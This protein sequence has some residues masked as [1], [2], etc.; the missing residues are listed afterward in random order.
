[1]SDLFLFTTLLRDLNR[2]EFPSGFIC[3]GNDCVVACKTSGKVHHY[4][5]PYNNPSFLDVSQPSIGITEARVSINDNWL[6]CQF[7]RQKNNL[8]I[9]NYFDLNEKH[10]VL[11]AFGDY[12]VTTETLGG[13][14]RAHE[15]KINSSRSYNF[16]E[17]L[18]QPNQENI[19]TKS[20]SDVCLPELFGFFCTHV[21]YCDNFS[22]FFAVCK[23]L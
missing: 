22:F 15:F 13:Q 4:F 23:R 14:T 2:T 8:K 5:N 19:A 3:K 16:V 9:S 20:I 10:F 12:N 18:R 7:K 17:N 1:M 6:V 11:A 21:K